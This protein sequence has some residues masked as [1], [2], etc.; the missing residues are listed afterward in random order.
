MEEGPAGPADAC[1][2][3]RPFPD[4]FDSCRTYQGT[5]FVGLDL[6]YR[7][8]RPSR[9]CRFLTVGEVSGARGSFYGR[10]ALGDGAARQRW[11]ERVDRE[12]LQKLNELRVKLAT[13]MRPQ[14]EELWRLKGDQ[15]RSQKLGEARDADATTAA[16]EAFSRRV[17][18]Q[19]E[20]FLDLQSSTLAELQLP[21]DPLIQL[22]RLS[23]DSFVAQSTA[24]QSEVEL[25]PEVLARFP[26]E[27]LALLRPDSA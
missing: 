4:D 8:L 21:R 6:Q 12:R 11:I 27:V 18:A 25:P 14:I 10:C 20:T 2:Y 24:E 3:P 13:V 22:T 1:P 5:L 15:L 19:I 16:L 26:P 7:P 17:T 9:T 23:L